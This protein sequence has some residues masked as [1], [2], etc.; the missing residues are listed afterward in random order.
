V[1]PPRGVVVR[2]S[3]DVLAI[4]DQH[5]ARAMRY[6]REHA[7]HGIR[8]RDVL[9]QVPLSRVALATRFKAAIGHTI[10][11]EIQRVQIRRVQQLLGETEL[12]IKQIAHR[13]GFRYVEYMTRL[14]RRVTGRTP[15]KFRHLPSAIGPKASAP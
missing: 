4:E 11:A 8:P 7:C 15:A 2:Q 13:A 10:G 14:F 1:V 3:T 5:V 6:V 12:P 9:A